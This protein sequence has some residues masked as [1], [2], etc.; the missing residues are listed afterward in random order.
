MS[1]LSIKEIE[2]EGEGIT[3][4]RSNTDKYVVLIWHWTKSN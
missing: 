4:D 3:K 2:E 1:F